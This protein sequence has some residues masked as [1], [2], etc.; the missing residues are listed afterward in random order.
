MGEG[1]RRRSQKP[2]KCTGTLGAA[3]VYT[4]V[5]WDREMGLFLKVLTSWKLDLHE[6]LPEVNGPRQSTEIKD[7]ARG[8]LKSCT[9]GSVLDAA[10][11]L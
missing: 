10:A 5:F 6:S 11:L 7:H 1:E 2:G 3:Q 4:D 8:P 9:T